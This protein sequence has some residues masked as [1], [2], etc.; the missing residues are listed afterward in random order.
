MRST[1]EPA[2]E[3]PKTG[4][5]IPAEI[6]SRVDAWW[7]LFIVVVLI[8]LALVIFKPDPYRDILAFVW[9]GVLVTL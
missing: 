1:D 2:S 7:G 4:R 6:G 8:I 3:A 5:L 9:D